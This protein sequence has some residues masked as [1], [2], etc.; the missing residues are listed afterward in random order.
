MKT[1]EQWVSE[2]QN[3]IVAQKQK[4]KF[5][6]YYPS[7]EMKQQTYVLVEKH[8]ADLGYITEFRV[9]ASCLNKVDITIGWN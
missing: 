8:F 9:C 6:I 1:A 7:A 4:G 3:Y 5:W 2:I